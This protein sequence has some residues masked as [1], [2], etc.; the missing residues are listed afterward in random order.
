M[1]TLS[2][3]PDNEERDILLLIFIITFSLFLCLLN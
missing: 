3:E 1:A 2:T